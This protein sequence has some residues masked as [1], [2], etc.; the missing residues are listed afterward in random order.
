[1]QNKKKV[2]QLCHASA[3]SCLFR[4]IIILIITKNRNRLGLH[5]KNSKNQ[6]SNEILQKSRQRKKTIKVIESKVRLHGHGRP[7]NQEL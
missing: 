2:Q 1:M 3:L 6:K 5:S 7:T 4:K